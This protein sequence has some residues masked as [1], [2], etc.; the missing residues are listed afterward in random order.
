MT[1]DNVPSDRSRNTERLTEQAAVIRDGC[2]V[3]AK[4]VLEIADTEKKREKG[5]MHREG[6]E[7]NHGMIF[8]FPTEGS[9]TFWMENIQIPLDMICISDNCEIIGIQHTD[10]D[11]SASVSDSTIYEM[12][13]STKYVIEIAQGF[14]NV[15]SIEQGDEIVFDTLAPKAKKTNEALNSLSIEY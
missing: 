6:L 14:T 5:L 15:A 11:L 7:Q 4:I 1:I 3:K 12:S 9:H 8:V 10:V 13:A 2:K